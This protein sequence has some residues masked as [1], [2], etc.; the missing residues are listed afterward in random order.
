MNAVPQNKQQTP[1]PLVLM[2]LDGWGINPRKEGNAI[3]LART[4]VYSKLQADF[5][6]A[7]LDASGPSVGLPDGQ[8]GNSEVG[9]LNIGAGRIVYQDFTLINQEIASGAFFRN[10]V[11]V[12]AM[13]GASSGRVHLLGLL[14]DGGVHS[15]IDHLFAL[16]KMAKQEGVREVYLH[17]FLDG[18]DTPP[19]SG[20]GYVRSLE[21][22][23]KKIGI[24]KVATISGRYYA[25]DRDNRWDRV[26]QA[27]NAIVLGQGEEGSDPVTVVERSY[28]AGIT[29]EFLKPAVILEGGK[30]RALIQDGDGVIFFNFRADRARELTRA[31]TEKEFGQFPR[32][33]FPRLSTFAC[34]KVYDE[35]FRLPAAFETRPLANIFGEVISDTGLAQLRIAETE[36]Y[37]HVTYFFNGGDEKSFPGEERVLIPSPKDVPTYDLKPEMS[38]YQVTDELVK[39]IRSGRYPFILV[40]YANPDMVGHT[41]ILPAAIRAV[42]VID[43]CLGKVLQAV[44]EQ[45]GVICLTSD[46]GDIE[47]MIDYETGQPHTAH[48]THLVPFIVTR[49]GL[50]LRDGIF[51]DIAPTLLQ[52]LGLPQPPEMTGQSLIVG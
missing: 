31:L 9:H 6:H 51:A 36:K 22:H 29:D 40:N 45:R 4:P 48:T 50:R 11:L 27:F 47:Q 15:H 35:T 44:Q 42:E 33:K 34:M 14:S 23:L 37:A 3:A 52:L 8:M 30:P 7:M 16:L 25:M 49:Q 24:G 18:R 1:G 20:L 12:N 46:H 43:D 41:G 2:I 26:Q 17:P 19:K 38:A 13:R 32:S 28:A 21:E 39:R 5:P 10:S